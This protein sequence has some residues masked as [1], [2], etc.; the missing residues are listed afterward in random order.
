M[1]RRW[2]HFVLPLGLWLAAT[3]CASKR[4]P[5]PRWVDLAP[6]PL[7]I[8]SAHPATTGQTDPP[9]ESEGPAVVVSARECVVIV[10][11]ASSRDPRK[12]ALPPDARRTGSEE[13]WPNGW[14]QA[15]ERSG[16]AWF[17]AHVS[18]GDRQFR[19]EPFTPRSDVGCEKSMCAS[20]RS[21]SPAVT[22]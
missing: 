14:V 22:K 2:S 15:V 21:R 19:C 5:A 16:K 17:I 4:E 10:A 3:A 7:E 8:R 12:V 20:L 18:V 6:L 13:A 1:L 11:N 9:L